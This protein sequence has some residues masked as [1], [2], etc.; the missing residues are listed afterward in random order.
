MQTIG[1]IFING[2]KVLLLVRPGKDCRYLKIRYSGSDGSHFIDE[3]LF[4][5]ESPISRNLLLDG[6]T[7]CL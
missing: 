7:I 5:K 6:E 2:I 1:H 4:L 3:E